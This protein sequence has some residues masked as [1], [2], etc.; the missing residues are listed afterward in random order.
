MDSQDRQRDAVSRV[1]GILR[2]VT[3]LVQLA[4]FVY[5]AFYSA[6]LIFGC[7]VQDDIVSLADGVMFSSP[8]ATAAM[9]VLSRVLKLCRWHKAA[10]LI[11][12]ASQ[13]EGVVDSYLFS[14]TQVEIIIINILFGVVSLVF[15]IVANKHFF[16]DGRKANPL[17]N[18]RLLQVQG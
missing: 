11:P 12:S 8:L 13:I 2:K 15:L 6:Y 1:F 7:F 14:F 5:L 9:L 17:R 3:R 16:H 4:P 10:C 18:A